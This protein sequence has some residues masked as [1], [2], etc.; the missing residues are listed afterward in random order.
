MALALAMQ[1]VQL[2]STP[3][4]TMRKLALHASALNDAEYT[5]YTSSLKEIAFADD[6]PAL[7]VDENDAFYE[8]ITIGVREARAWFRGRYAHVGAAIDGV[9]PTI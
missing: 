1:A 2:A 3:T 4:T 7:D 8:R 9:C 6:E 5:L